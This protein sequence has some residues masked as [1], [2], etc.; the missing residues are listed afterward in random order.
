MDK[1]PEWLYDEVK[2][3]GTDYSQVQEAAAY[4]Q[5]SR[6]Q[7][8]DAVNDFILNYLDLDDSK[9]VLDFGAGFGSFAMAAAARC[10][11][12]IAVDISPAMTDLA[13]KLA[14]EIGLTNIE[15]HTAGFLTY[16]H[17]S[18]PLDGVVCCGALHHLPDFWK[19][20]AVNRMY[21]ML[22][23]GGKM[24]FEDHV[25]SFEVNQYPQVLDDLIERNKGS[26]DANGRNIMA[27]LM[28]DEFPTCDWIM[29]GMIERAGFTIVN[30]KYGKT[31]FRG[32]YQCL[33]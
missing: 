30:K 1:I 21:A 2:T 25:L 10:K 14:R 24:H 13:A 32:F 11:K 15:F 23:P 8:R 9:V 18:T 20:V 22:K 27:V 5:R 7:D 3:F 16:E 26:V 33:K 6:S 31:G 29:E 19:Q 28:R 4:E 17:A 12:V